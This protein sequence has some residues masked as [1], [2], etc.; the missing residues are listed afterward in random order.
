MAYR[1]SQSGAISFQP[2]DPGLM[3]NGQVVRFLGDKSFKFL[4]RVI[5]ASLLQGVQATSLVQLM[6]TQM[7]DIDRQLVS[8]AS[9]AWL[10]QHHVISFSS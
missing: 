8:A 5:F 1:P 2:Y 4:G 9:K 6:R 10:Y 7:E 3:V